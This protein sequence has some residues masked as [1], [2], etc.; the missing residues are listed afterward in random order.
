MLHGVLGDKYYGKI[1]Q[2]QDLGRWVGKQVAMVTRVMRKQGTWE[3]GLEM[4]ELSTHVWGS[5]FWAD[6]TPHAKALKRKHI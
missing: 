2:R 3:T 5:T 1:I 4:R 6:R